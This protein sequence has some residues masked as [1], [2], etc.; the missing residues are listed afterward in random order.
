MAQAK[1]DRTANLTFL[2]III[3]NNRFISIF[4]ILCCV[5]T[6]V[7]SL[8]IPKEYT[9][10]ATVF[11]TDSNS[12]D[13]V[14]RNPQFGYDIEADRLIQI[15]DSREIRDSIIKKFSLVK[16]Y[17][18]DT[19]DADWY[20][21]ICKKYS[22]DITCTKTV[23]MSIVIS[24]RTKDPQMS[25]NIVNSIITMVNRTRERLLK[26]NVFRAVKSLESEYFLLKHD[27][28]SLNTL[29]SDIT[30]RDG[31]ITQFMHSEKYLSLIM[32]KSHLD[33]YEN[34]RELQ[35]LV[36]YYNMRLSWFYDVEVKLKNA[37]LLALRPLPAIYVVEK[38]IP[39]Y[40][41]TFPSYGLNLL[42][43]FAGSLIFILV[44][45]FIWEKI[46]IVREQLKG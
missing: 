16:Y 42:I 22:R 25:A 24:A 38:A 11:A 29:I 20:F 31:G 46:R 15:L 43:S 8:L 37:N 13:D 36:N 2:R 26:Q 28:D 32:E 21:G 33:K 35:L 5:I 44:L 1:T 3:Q 41:K 4:I 6:L 30:R 12:L 18:I 14:I 10:T 45:L 34:S 7:I 27:L 40:R 9:S 17:N 23:Y 19:T 39:S